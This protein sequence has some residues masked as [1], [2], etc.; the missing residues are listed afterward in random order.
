MLAHQTLNIHNSH[1]IISARMQVR[2]SARYAG[3][4][5]ADQARISLAT[6]CLMEG[7]GLGKGTSQSSVAIEQLNDGKNK[8][9]RVVFTITKPNEHHPLQTAA[10]SISWMVDSIAI[11][12]LKNERVE[13]VLT[14]WVIRR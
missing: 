7:I 14:K 2:E 11:N 12:E 3:M 5:L 6:S 4:N 9:V 10:G 13:I 8:G 1:D